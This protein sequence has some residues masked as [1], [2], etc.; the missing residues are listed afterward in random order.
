[1]KTL[2]KLT[3]VLTTAAVLCYAAFEMLNTL[4]SLNLTSY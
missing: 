4:S 2:T 3:L 1:M